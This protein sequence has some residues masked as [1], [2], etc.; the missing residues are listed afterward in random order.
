MSRS[1][2][3]LN[4]SALTQKHFK[5]KYEVRVDQ[6]ASYPDGSKNVWHHGLPF[7]IFISPKIITSRCVMMK[8]R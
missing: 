5:I 2:L 7:G 4:G 8:Y 6:F 3:I 1:R